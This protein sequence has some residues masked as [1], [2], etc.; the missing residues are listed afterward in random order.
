MPMY[1]FECSQCQHVFE[2]LLKMSDPN[3]EVCPVCKKGPVRKLISRSGFVLKGGGFYTNEYPSAARQAG[4][5][6]ES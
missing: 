5:K 1:E 2:E 6:S 4:S 3:P